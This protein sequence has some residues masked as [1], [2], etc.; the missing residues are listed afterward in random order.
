LA[1]RTL[2]AL[3][4]QINHD[5]LFLVEVKVDFEKIKNLLFSLEFYNKEYVRTPRGK[6]EG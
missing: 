6:V 5:I 1:K 3:I 4:K 2:R